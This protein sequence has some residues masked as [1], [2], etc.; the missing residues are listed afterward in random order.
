LI[1]A[2]AAGNE[3]V[4]ASGIALEVLAN[5]RTDD[6]VESISPDAAAAT[7][8]RLDRYLH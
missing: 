1:S 4:S 6:F 2:A 8:A 3:L 5:E 7:G